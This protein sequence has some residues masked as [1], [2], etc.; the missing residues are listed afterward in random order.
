[1]ARTH[2]SSSGRDSGSSK[3][4]ERC[5]DIFDTLAESCGW[6]AIARREST[7]STMQT[8]DTIRLSLN[9]MNSFTP[10]SSISTSPWDS[11]IPFEIASTHL[12]SG[13]AKTS[14]MVAAKP[15]SRHEARRSSTRPR[16]RPRAFSVSQPSAPSSSVHFVWMQSFI[17]APPPPGSCAIVSNAIPTLADMASAEGRHPEVWSNAP[18]TTT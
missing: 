2:R 12:S 14:S 3:A 17:R 8:T 10:T 13:W 16:M 6:A 5:S 15:F 1:M 11:G 9:D 18:A 4:R 7:S